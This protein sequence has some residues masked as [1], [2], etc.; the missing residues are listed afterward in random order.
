MATLAEIRS[1]LP[2]IIRD[3]A[4][5]PIEDIQPDRTFTG[6]L[7]IDSLSM[8]EILVACE[9]QFGVKIPDEQLKQLT[10][11]DDVVAYIERSQP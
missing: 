5:V 6:D 10:T 9:E 8:V 7:D 1:E 3:V 4:G 11:V 2:K